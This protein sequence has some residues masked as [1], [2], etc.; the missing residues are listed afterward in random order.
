MVTPP[1]Q[2]KDVPVSVFKNQLSCSIRK[3]RER[4]RERERRER[5]DIPSMNTSR[6]NGHREMD[7][8]TREKNR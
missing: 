8:L 1:G 7:A 4:E 2:T 3:E 6:N 5:E